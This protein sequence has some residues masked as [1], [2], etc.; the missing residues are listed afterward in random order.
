MWGWII[1]Q[2]R[3]FI[4]SM[5]VRNRGMCA[6]FN[7]SYLGRTYI[8]FLSVL[9]PRCVYSQA[10]HVTKIY[11]AWAEYIRHSFRSKVWKHRYYL[12]RFPRIL[13]HSFFKNLLLHISANICCA[14]VGGYKFT[15]LPHDLFTHAMHASRAS[16]IHREPRRGICQSVTGRPTFVRMERAREYEESN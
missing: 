16:V 10:P 14:C 9:I 4:Y 6:E 3:F 8:W 7:I 12:G 15:N 5:G 1:T 13:R 11:P 2:R